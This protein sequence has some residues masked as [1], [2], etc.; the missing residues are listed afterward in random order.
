VRR[1][2]LRSPPSSPARRLLHC[3]LARDSLLSIAQVINATLFAA[4]EARIAAAAA[5]DRQNGA[6]AGTSRW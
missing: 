1:Q 4:N 6:A 5:G 2:P 3:L